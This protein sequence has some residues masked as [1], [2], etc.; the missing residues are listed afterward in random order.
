[1]DK[2]AF[3][4]CSFCLNTAKIF[5]EK[6]LQEVHVLGVDYTALVRERPLGGSHDKDK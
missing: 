2:R 4:S 1:M 5:P 6:K 3:S